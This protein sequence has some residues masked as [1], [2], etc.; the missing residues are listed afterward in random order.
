MNQTPQVTL[1]ELDA[2]VGVRVMDL[3]IGGPGRYPVFSRDI[4]A[5]WTIVNK[6]TADGYQFERSQFP[7]GWRSTFDAELT[8]SSETGEAD[9]CPT[10]MVAI[11]LAAL[12]T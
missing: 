2:L 9:D 8:T 3:P 1:A 10:P 7:D 6:L 4:A 12:G 11:C 5:A